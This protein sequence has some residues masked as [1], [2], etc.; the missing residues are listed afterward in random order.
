MAKNYT[1]HFKERTSS[2][3][4]EAPSYLV[5]ITHP[6]LAVPI[7]VVNDTQDLVHNGNTF[8]A[9]AFRIQFPEDIA[10]TMPRVPVAI[11]NVG[12]ELTQWLEASNGGRGAQFRIMQV[13]RDTPDVVEQEYTMTL[14]SAR[15]NIIEVSG[16][17]GYE[18]FLDQPCMAALYSP[19]TA[20]GL[21]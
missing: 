11:D 15:Q 14:L 13:M 20:P 21:F 8:I 5:E 7:R 18:N 16:E 2:T 6:Q 17:L 19:E 10:Q 12:R 1:E 3:S 9:C 4:G